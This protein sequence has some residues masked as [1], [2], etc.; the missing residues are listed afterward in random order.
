MELKRINYVLI[1]LQGL[2]CERHKLPGAKLPETRGL[3][4]N[5]QKIHGLGCKR[6]D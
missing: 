6:N 2:N 1:G 5:L 4:L 3:N